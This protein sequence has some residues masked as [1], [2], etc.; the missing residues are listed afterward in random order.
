MSPSPI[1]CAH[2]GFNFMRHT[3]DENVPKL[4]NNCML[5]E[6]KNK[7]KGE[8]PMS[9]ANILIVCDRED[10]IQIEEICTNQG[11]TLSQYFMDLHKLNTSKGWASRDEK[12]E[13]QNSTSD[14]NREEDLVPASIPNKKPKGAKK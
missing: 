13:N 4:C 7:P 14:R 2:C 6:E 1:P 10:Q 11:I 12:E 9:K 8:R 3:L 5:K